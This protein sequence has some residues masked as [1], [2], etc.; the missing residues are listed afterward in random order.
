MQNGILC[1]FMFIYALCKRTE[2]NPKSRIKSTKFPLKCRIEC[3]NL[4]FSVKD[5]SIT[6]WL[7][8]LIKFSICRLFYH[9][10]TG[11][12]IVFQHYKLLSINALID[13]FEYFVA[14]N[15]FE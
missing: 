7:A 8:F 14:L 3:A 13:G 4:Y 10:S 6:T 15:F 5:F 9:F 1:F 2:E 11:F 12:F